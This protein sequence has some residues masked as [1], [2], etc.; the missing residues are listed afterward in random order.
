MR[1]LTQLRA[2]QAEVLHLHKACSRER[3]AYVS[4]AEQAET[5]EAELKFAVNEDNVQ[6]QQATGGEATRK[7]AVR[8]RCWV[9]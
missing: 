9:R 6:M 2:L 3:A 7:Q 8:Q 5:V 4:E 1:P